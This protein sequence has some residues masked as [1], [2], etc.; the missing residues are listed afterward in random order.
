MSSN[1]IKVLSLDGGGVRGLHTLAVLQELETTYGFKVK[2]HFDVFGGTST[3][4]LL[5][6]LYAA[7]YET[8]DL[9][10]LYNVEI[11]KI[12]TKGVWRKVTSGFGLFDEKYSN[13]ALS[14]AAMK[15]VGTTTMNELKKPAYVTTVDITSTMTK[16]IGPDS[17]MLARLA[18]LSTSAAPTYFPP[19]S[20][21]DTALV[22]GGLVANNPSV[23]LIT[24]VMKDHK[25]KTPVKIQMLSVGTGYCPH[26]ITLKRA[27]GMG[28][29]EWAG[30]ISGT[31]MSV[32][33]GFYHDIAKVLL[34]K[35][36]LRINSEMPHDVAL[37]SLD[38]DDWDLLMEIGKETAK[39]TLKADLEFI[40]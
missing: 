17:Q 18:V 13:K 25:L 31:M 33:S 36:Y 4:G 38:K 20:V 35:N 40:L 14:A 3:G 2:D 21:G 30:P 29:L 34:G 39:S 10:N 6:V 15:Y 12:F 8:S 24:E 32:Q 7:G 23:A 16:V 27:E 9:L 26:G 28:A 5:A 11:P 37:D 22:D 19:V 1:N